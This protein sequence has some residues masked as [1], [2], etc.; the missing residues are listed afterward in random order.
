M[1]EGYELNLSFERLLGEVSEGITVSDPALPDNPL[2]Y[3]NPGFTR[4]TGYTGKDVLG[5]NCRFLQGPGTDQEELDKLR[6]AIRE[7]KPCVVELLNYRKDGSPFWNNV[8]VSPVFNAAGELKHFIGVQMDVTRR[9]ELEDKQSQFIGNLAH[10]LKTPLAAIVGLAETLQRQQ[11]LTEELRGGLYDSLASQSA[12]LRETI[13]EI[14]DLSR[15]DTVVKSEARELLDMRNVVQGAVDSNSAFAGT[16]HISF[17]FEQ[18]DEEVPVLGDAWSLHLM[19]S[20][21]L[22]NAIKYS[23]EKSSVAISLERLQTEARVTVSDH[24][25]GID[26]EEQQKIFDRFYRTDKARTRDSGGTGL[27]LTIANEVAR[28]HQGRIKLDSK[29]GRGSTFKVMLPLV[30]CLTNPGG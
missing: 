4:L 29:P 26:P 18:P 9:R 13:E 23:P 2:V 6:V 21:L 7:A 16:R 19:V 11:Q 10:E 28:L 1:L 20:N 12:R 22:S 25:P 17:G 27:G 5:R 14:L 30:Y 24:G 8:S 15:I 3:V